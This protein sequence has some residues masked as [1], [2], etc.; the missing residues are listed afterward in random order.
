MKVSID[1]ERC[2]GHTACALTTPELF[3][4][5]DDDAISSV[6]AGDVRPAQQSQARLGANSCPE[7]AI[8]ISDEQLRVQPRPSAEVDLGGR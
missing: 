7:P 4:F 5:R 1:P 3:T 2:R 6:V 8:V